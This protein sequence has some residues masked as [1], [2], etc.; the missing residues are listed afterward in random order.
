MSIAVACLTIIRSGD[1]FLRYFRYRTYLN[2][3]FDYIDGPHPY[4][5]MGSKVS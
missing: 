2:L 3:L 4:W 5:L 1:I